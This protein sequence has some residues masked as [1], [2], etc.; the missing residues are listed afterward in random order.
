MA[1]SS[2]CAQDTQAGHMAAPRTVTRGRWPVGKSTCSTNMRVR[3]RHRCQATTHSPAYT[4]Q[5]NPHSEKEGAADGPPESL[6]EECAL[7]S[8]PGCLLDTHLP[9]SRT[10]PHANKCSCIQRC[11]GASYM[12]HP[13]AGLFVATGQLRQGCQPRFHLCTGQANNSRVQLLLDSNR[14]HILVS[15][16]PHTFISHLL[17]C[18]LQSQAPR[19]PLQARP[20]RNWPATVI[21]ETQSKEGIG[22]RCLLTLRWEDS[23]LEACGDCLSCHPPTAMQWQF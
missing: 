8:I 21:L 13:S 9:F 19:V 22:V 3:E 18:L 5:H 14:G 7:L 10:R 17:R 15:S 12:H 1:S 23:P 16:L 11:L 20:L 2:A 4:T 6:R